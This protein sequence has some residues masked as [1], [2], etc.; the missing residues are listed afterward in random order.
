VL[1]KVIELAKGDTCDAAVLHHGE[2]VPR[3]E[4]RSR[5]AATRPDGLADQA[6]AYIP[7]SRPRH[8]FI[9]LDHQAPSRYHRQALQG[10]EYL[11]ARRSAIR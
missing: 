1:V 10:W 7:V 9:E 2:L 11:D 3:P 4:R 6:L 5:L 8:V